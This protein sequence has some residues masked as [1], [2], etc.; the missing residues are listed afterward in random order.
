MYKKVDYPEKLCPEC[1]E[2][3]KP[4][5]KNGTVC[6]NS[7]KSKRHYY[8]NPEKTK[9]KSLGRDWSKIKRKYTYNCMGCGKDYYPKNGNRKKYCSRECAFKNRDMKKSCALPLYS[10]IYE[11]RCTVCNKYF[12]NNKKFGLICS[13]ECTITRAEQ[14]RVSRLKAHRDMECSRC[15]I[16]YCPLIGIKSRS[17]A[18]CEDGVTA[19][20]YV[21]EL[22]D[23]RN[24]EVFY[25]GKGSNNRMYHH[26]KESDCKNKAK[27]E[28]IRA[29]GYKNVTRL[30]VAEFW[31]EAA[32]YKYE[33]ERIAM[34]E[35]L[36]NLQ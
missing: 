20:W 28:M 30:K 10:R 27:Q 16:P 23:P 18:N 8:A 4:K 25:V 33:R 12:Y 22:I 15:G 5:S 3:F 31:D 34:Y 11:H 2:M 13:R 32:A 7:C 35:G 17:C 26:G 21:Y 19:R 9:A 36:T 29:I 14:G 1:G 6:S 24:H